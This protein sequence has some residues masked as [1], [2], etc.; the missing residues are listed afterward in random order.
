M[1]VPGP[2][3][4][5]WV[6]AIAFT[7]L[8][9]IAGAVGHLFRTFESGEKISATIVLIKTLAAGV[10]GFL[11]YLLCLA[12]NFNDIWSGIIVGV[13]GWLGADTTISVL[14]GFVYNMMKVDKTKGEKE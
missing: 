8:A 12:L 2:L 9:I 10:T 11:M 1:Q 3:D 5:W 4:H 6:K 13:F 14:K 7:V